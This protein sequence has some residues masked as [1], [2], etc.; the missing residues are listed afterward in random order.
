MENV[1]QDLSIL[2]AGEVPP[3]P[4]ELLALRTFDLDQYPAGG[5]RIVIYDT[6]AGM[7][8]ADASRCGLACGAAA[9]VARRHKT[10]FNDI[11][12]LMK[13]SVA[14]IVKCWARF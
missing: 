9:V 13:S 12:M 1:I 2:P 5:V 3:N 14:S 10:A 7:D 6:A 11:S 8:Y 4:Q